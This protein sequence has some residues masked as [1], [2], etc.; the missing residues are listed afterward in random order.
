MVHAVRRAWASRDPFDRAVAAG[1]FAV[2]AHG[3]VDWH[4]VHVSVAIPLG[5]LVGISWAPP[6]T[7]S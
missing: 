3:L 1:V 4:L 2:A 6:P 5:I 7:R